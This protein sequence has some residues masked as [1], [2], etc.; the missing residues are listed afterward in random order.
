MEIYLGTKVIIKQR[1]RYFFVLL[2]RKLNNFTR[3]EKLFLLDAYALIYRAYYA[4][5]KN[6]RI[7]SKG[8]NTS[9]IMGFVNTLEDVLKKENPTHI[10][11]AFDPAGPTFRHEAFEQYKAQREETPEA[12]RLSVPI[13]KD[14]IR[15]YRIPIL[16]VS[17]YEADDVI[18]TLATEAGK[19]GITTYMMTPDKDYGQLVSENVFM[20]RPKYGDK[21]F[22]VMGVNEIKA[23]FDIESP[24]QVIDMLGL[25]GDTADNIPGCP[26]VGE[27]TAQKLIAQFGSIENLL[28]NTDQLKGAIKTKVENNREQITFSKFLATIKTDVPISLDMEAL[29]REQP[30]EEELRKIFEELEFRTLL[31]RILKTEKKTAAPS[32]PVQS[33]LF[34]FFS[35]ENTDEPK[36]S[37]LTRL[38]D[39]DFDYQLLDSEE[40]IDDFLQII[41]TKDFFSLDTETTGTDPI[42]AELVGMSFSFAE[43]QAFYVPVPANREEALAIVKKLKPIIENEKT[44]KIGQNIK[45]DMLVLGNYGVEVR[46]PMFDTMIAHY[47]LQP[48]LHHGMDYLAE[49]YLKYE[50]I[51]IEELI[52]PKG[53][54][55][56][57]MRD[58][59]PTSVYKYA[60]ED[61]DVT[62]KLKKVLEKELIEN[63]VNELFQTIEMPL[64]PVLAY[65]ERNGVR[66]D[67]EA[68]KETSQ[69]FTARM[70]QLEE[71]VHQLA[72]MEFNI[73][74]P[75][76]V[77]EV[78]FDRLKIT[79]K[80]K[81][82]KTGQY[83]TSEEVLESLR[84]KHEIV[85]KILEHRGLK[86]LLGT[87]ID[88]LPL[89]INPK[90]GHIHTSFNQTVTATGR[91]SSS[92]P[93]LQNIPI[94]NEDGKEIRR[95]FIPDE[96]CE[97]FSADYSQIELRI[98]AHL[99][100]DPH[101]IEAFQKGQDIHAATAAKIYKE[102]LEDVTREQRSKAK[103]ANFGI[104]YGISVFGLAER[105]NIERKE[106][107][108]LIDGYFENYPH[109]KEYMD[110]S[111]RLAQEKGYIETIFKRKRYLPDINSRNA[112]VRGYAERNA[113]NAPIQ[114][115][116]ADIIKVAMIRIY[117]RFMEEGIRSKMILQVHDELNFSVVPEEKEKVQHIV[118][119]EMEAA[120]KMKVPLQADCDWGKN[121]LEAH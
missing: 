110:Q 42:T 84:G 70:K 37:N 121:W 77:G 75:K 3:M 22:E 53:K 97:F 94:R 107:K 32:A 69:H 36:N 9:A 95:A 119:S 72:G 78:L 76:Q 116:A 54:N 91:L 60:C 106:A 48:E 1:I 114:G 47:V 104:I 33:D 8:F 45:Y 57:N 51:K 16:E 118:I 11:I 101:M 13:I 40:K 109:V 105:L 52:G 92:N 56:K 28:A 35:G 18:G 59:S 71:E 63:N 73:A 117:K 90:T 87:Y 112:V 50:T 24:S 82:T 98:M 4:F 96:G 88:A 20:Y 89:L 26:G 5:I 21:E 38:E 65:M 49:V 17:G 55:Q 30:D 68:L 25:M 66:I 85:G 61:A 120:Y 79:D 46:G 80:A 41:V 10:G 19:R 43:N 93:N 62:L 44:L 103:T 34:G 100:G 15:A 108:E 74:S 31:D 111:I 23:K 113:I 86:K 2:R 102:K 115:S 14:I 12:I 29:K 39:L 67:T 27:K 83:V 99:S 81:K 6:P 58:L 7:N 64:V